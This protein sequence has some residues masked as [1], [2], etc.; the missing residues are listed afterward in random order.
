MLVLVMVVWEDWLPVSLI[1]L[2]L[3]I[4]LLGVMELDI[5]ME[6]S[7]KRFAMDAKLSFLT[8]G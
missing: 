4:T 5:S 3:W 6:C 8:I 1:L 2:Q 7:T